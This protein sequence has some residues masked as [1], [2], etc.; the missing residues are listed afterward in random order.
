MP[1]AKQQPLPHRSGQ[2][3]ATL[4][5]LPARIFATPPHSTTGNSPKGFL[6]ARHDHATIIPG[7]H[8]YVCRRS[9]FQPHF[10]ALAAPPTGY[11]HNSR[12]DHP[13]EVHRPSVRIAGGTQN[14]V[15]LPQFYK[16]T[17]TAGC[18]AHRDASRG[19]AACDGRM[20]RQ[21]NVRTVHREAHSSSSTYW[22]RT[23][24][25]GACTYMYAR[26]GDSTTPFWSAATATGGEN[27]PETAV[28][29]SYHT[30]L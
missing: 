20:G 25:P 3:E 27:K 30:T 1:P 26:V 29:R 15:P 10:G 28:Q 19:D 24:E 6:P 22:S 12:G 5:L 17:P 14:F 11:R 23:F 7:V 18:G 2:R 16:A 21:N 9:V 4:H 8:I 13:Y